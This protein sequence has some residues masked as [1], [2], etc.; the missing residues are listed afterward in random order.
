MAK[1]SV[2]HWLNFRRNAKKRL[3][4]LFLIIVTLG[5]MSFTFVFLT[6]SD[7][8]VRIVN[9]PVINIQGADRGR[10]CVSI[11]H[12]LDV[13]GRSECLWQC[14]QFEDEFISPS[15]NHENAFFHETS[16]ARAL[17]IRQACA[18]ESAALSNPNLTIYLLMTTGDIDWNSTTMKTLKSYDNVH[19]HSINLGEYFSH[20]PF[21]EWYFC[22]T[23]NYGSHAISHLSDALRFLTL[24]KYGGYYFDLD[25]IMLQSVMQYHNFIGAENEENLA[26]GALHVEY[27]HPVIRAAVEEFRN[28]Y[29]KDIWGHNGPLLL[30]R[31]MT[32]WCSADNIQAMT[33]STCYGFRI[34]PPMAF[35]P[36]KWF[37]WETYFL[38]ED[39]E[40]R[41]ETI[42]THVWNKKSVDT[43]VYKNST[44]AY[45]KL[46]RSRC[47]SVFAVAPDVF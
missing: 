34:L 8:Y 6:N 3:H 26:A 44:Q 4:K 47:P 23:W 43:A 22:S 27:L 46:A 45:V 7:F 15:K 13:C 35:Y 18:V 42:G 36:V 38:E 39:I 31:V 33:T 14:P 16:G 19:V 37:N 5:L 25:V 29:R 28:T 21:E 2:R 41:N 32:K 40:W 17:D 12:T 11:H 9:K 30:T 10:C 20:T 1:S 24:Y